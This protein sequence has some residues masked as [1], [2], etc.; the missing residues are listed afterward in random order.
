MTSFISWIGID[1]RAPS[2]LYFASDSRISWESKKTW[3]YAQKVFASKTQ[4][5]LI[6]Y[7]GDVLF[8]SQILGQVVNLIDN[9]LLY[10]NESRPEVRWST[11]LSIIQST[12][13]KYPE[14]HKR[15][16]TIVYATRENSGMDSIFHMSSI[17]WDSKKDWNDNKWI[18]LPK[19][20]DLIYSIGSGEKSIKKWYSHWSNTK[21]TR[22]SRSVFSAFC[23]SLNSGDDLLSGGAPQLIGLYRIGFAQSFG[24][25]YNKKRYISGIPVSTSELLESIEWRNSLFERCDWMSISTRKCT[26]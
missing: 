5:D 26:I 3:D 22:T 16:F 25:I 13:R 11:I 19:E 17:N 18:E 10:T 6:G 15:A 9:N 4:A 14:N 8:P 21:H 1:S 12:F 23:D 20:S 7:I 24:T 2:S